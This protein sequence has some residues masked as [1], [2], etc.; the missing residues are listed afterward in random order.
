MTVSNR[1]ALYAMLPA[2]GIF[3]Y[4]MSSIFIY[5][6]TIEAR[7]S[8]V[9]SIATSVTVLFLISERLRDSALRKL[10]FLNK[11]ALSPA[12]KASK[13]SIQSIDGDQAKIFSRSSELL[14]RHGRFLR[15]KLYPKNLLTSLDNASESVAAYEILWEKILDKGYKA[16]GM[17]A[18]NIW[19]LLKGIGF[20]VV[21][22]Y[23][24][25]QLTPAKEFFEALKKTDP[26]LA[27]Q[28][29]IEGRKTLE[30]KAEVLKKLEDFFAD[31][32]LEEIQE[33]PLYYG[34]PGMPP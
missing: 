25:E 11:R 34:F 28:F 29:P 33:R 19:A 32:Q 31:N 13:G 12:L 30:V 6:P 8:I 2:A 23:G 18:F 20:D 27:K 24:A 5:Q 9:S 15:L 10:E 3:V 14:R 4:G 21:G 26:E 7:V 17:S 16:M 1:V 22:N